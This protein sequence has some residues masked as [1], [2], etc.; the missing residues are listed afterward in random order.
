M[1]AR[2]WAGAALAALLI[3]GVAAAEP[4]VTVRAIE[5][6]Q[7][8]AADAKSAGPVPEG[9]T[10]DVLRREGAWV[11]LKAGNATGWAKLFDVKAPAAAGKGGGGSG[12]AQTLGLASGTRGASVTTGVRGLD[13]DMLKAAQPSAQELAAFESHAASKSQAQAFA[14]SGNLQT[15]AVDPIGG[16]R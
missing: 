6:R 2:T 7:A 16:T 12:I 9:V 14:K 8:P 15:R 4:A 5:L 13:A 10:V 1:R 3:A 11:Q